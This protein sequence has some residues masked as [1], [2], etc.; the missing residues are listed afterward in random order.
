M[1]FI[2]P[3]RPSG[4]R[5]D[6]RAV[7]AALAVCHTVSLGMRVQ[8]QDFPFAGRCMGGSTVQIQ[9]WQSRLW[10]MTSL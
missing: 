1:G 2:Q 10:A 4:E 3:A 6:L 9:V 8:N 5:S 7:T